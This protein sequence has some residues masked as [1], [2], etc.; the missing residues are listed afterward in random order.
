MP[1]N[2]NIYKLYNHLV[3][4]NHH[5]ALV[6]EEYG[7]TAGVVTME[8]VLETLLGLEITDEFDSTVDLQEYARKRWMVRA[9]RLGIE[10]DEEKDLN[11]RDK[12]G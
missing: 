4:E 9:R 8:D 11:L 7:G 12:Q 6:V 10:I 1:D 3:S 5:I 2:Q